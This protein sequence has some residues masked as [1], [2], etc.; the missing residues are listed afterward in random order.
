MPKAQYLLDIAKLKSGDIILSSAGEIPSASVRA[1]TKGDYSH[2]MLHVGNGSYI[3]SDL[4]G[5]HA[6]NIQR[7]LLD[8]P[9]R[10]SVL[11]V[12]GENRERIAMDAIIY[13]RRKVGTQYSK[14]EA[15]G[16]VL[17]KLRANLTNRQFC[18]RLVAQAYAQAGLSLVADAD[19]CTPQD[20]FNCEAL[21]EISGCVR[22]A[23]EEDVELANRFNPLELQRRNTNQ[24]LADVRKISG[25]DI[26][27]QQQVVDCVR[28]NP[29]YDEAIS[30]ALQRS[31]YLEFWRIDVS[32]NPWRYD[33]DIWLSSGYS[34]DKLRS[35]ASSEIDSAN[36]VINR[37]S[38]MCSQYHVLNQYY[39]RRYFQLERD[40]FAQ[41]VKLHTERREEARRVLKSL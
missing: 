20:L 38:F 35:T 18:S 13:A 30:E 14:R 5:V 28:N 4:T 33:A 6:D 12:S 40:L 16:V 37:Y 31:G 3:H 26:Q 11:R 19:Y 36:E 22:E 9:D 17:N 24:F 27:E 10:F 15:A 23:T 32:I 41:L 1:V 34:V 39:P 2:A 29:H 8:S 21:V 7:L 25:L